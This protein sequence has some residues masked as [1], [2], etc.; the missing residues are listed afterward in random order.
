MILNLVASLMHDE[1][2]FVLSVFPIPRPFEGQ[3]SQS[4]NSKC[5]WPLTVSLLDM[6]CPY[7]SNAVSG[8]Y[9]KPGHLV[10]HPFSSSE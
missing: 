3:T 1:E 8:N 7:H 5:S 9:A 4:A 2:Y 6:D 10:F